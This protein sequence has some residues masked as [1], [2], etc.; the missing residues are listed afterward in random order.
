MV[1]PN[2]K[3]TRAEYGERLVKARR[4]MEAK[5]IDLLICS[6]PSNMNWLTGYDGW[7]F[8]VHQA[9]LVPPQGEPVWY[10]RGQDANGAKRTAYLPHDNIVSYADHYVQ[11]TE[12]HP[13]DCLAKIIAERGW[14]KLTIGVEMDNY[15]FSAAAFNSLQRHLPNAR[16]VDA[17]A[18]VNWQRAV[19]SPTE[20]DYMRKAAR[21]VEAMH[22]RI[23]DKIE[24]GMRKCDLVAEIYDTGIRGVDCPDGRIGGDYPAIVPLLPSGADASAPHLTWDDKPMKANEGTFFEIAGCYNRYHAP[25]SRTVFLGKP[26]QAFLDAEKATLEGMEAGLAAAKPGN[27]CEDIANAFFSVLKKYGI[28][29]D[30]RTGYPIGVSYPPD[31]GERTM[32]LR[33]GDR[34]ELK[35]GMTFHFMTGL[36]LET[37]GLEI[38]ES[39][40]ITETGVECLANVPRKLFV[41]D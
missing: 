25:L 30:N 18:L 35:P 39:I 28:V 8:Y 32:S 10:G 5:G 31:W 20:I 9:V 14:D 4:A 37:M 2:L 6:D 19:K 23:V 38:T 16:F 33:P 24:V 3:F 12:R 36:W 7:S 1:E 27:T 15:W 41:K 17:T 13:M 26:T 11:S 29:K 34:S 40:L 22:Q 21:I